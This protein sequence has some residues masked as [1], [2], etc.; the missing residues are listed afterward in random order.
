VESV[1]TGLQ[2]GSGVIEFGLRGF[3]EE[4]RSE[5]SSFPVFLESLQISCSVLLLP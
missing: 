2:V 1:N 3:R 5:S 4:D